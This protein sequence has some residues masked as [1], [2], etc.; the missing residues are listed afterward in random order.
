MGSL[1]V[2]VVN[3][4]GNDVV[5]VSLAKQDELGETF[6]FYLPHEFLR[7]AVQVRAPFRQGVGPHAV[8]L[9]GCY[10][11]FR[12]LA[13][14]IVHDDIG[15][16]LPAIRCAVNEPLRLLADPF[17]V[18]VCGG[19]RDVDFAGFHAEEHEQVQLAE[20]F[21]RDRLDGEK[22][23]S[24]QRFFVAFK[25]VRPRVRRAIRTRFDSFFL[26]DVANRLSADLVD[27]QL[28]KLAE[29]SGVAEARSP[30][31]LNYELSNFFGFSLS[32]LWILRLL[33]SQRRRGTTDRKW[34]ALRS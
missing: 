33:S 25:E 3:V 28:S 29:D 31:D 17:R 13:V 22:V 10:E 1:L 15:F 5:E 24:P 9:D 19:W 4:F 7:S 21:G 34:M 11:V 26:Q 30:R 18:G 23:T 32:A 8:L 14:A 16:L 12:K 6:G 20:S 27:A 2:E